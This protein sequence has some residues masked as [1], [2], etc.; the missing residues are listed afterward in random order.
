MRSTEP[1]YIPFLFINIEDTTGP[2]AILK[3]VKMPFTELLAETAEKLK[4]KETESYPIMYANVRDREMRKKKAESFMR[5]FLLCLVPSRKM[6][7]VIW[8]GD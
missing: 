1:A 3:T 2:A 4:I 5:F 8:G 6:S 7:T